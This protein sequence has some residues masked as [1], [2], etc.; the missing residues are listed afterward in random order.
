MAAF[1]V[2]NLPELLE[3]M[4][5]HLPTINVLIA[6]RVSTFWKATIDGSDQLQKALCFRAAKYAQGP[7]EGA[8][9]PVIIS[10]TTGAVD[11]L[12]SFRTAND[13]FLYNP[14]FEVLFKRNSGGSITSFW[15]NSKI[16]H[17]LRKDGSSSLN[18]MLAFQPPVNNADIVC[19]W[20]ESHHRG[21]MDFN[22]LA[23]EN[24]KGIRVEDVFAQLNKKAETMGVY[25]LDGFAC[26]V[27]RSCASNRLDD[28]D[29]E[30]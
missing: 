10:Q 28:S 29:D 19:K 2:L 13:K 18:K 3:N 1:N 7:Q 21:E 6:T 9:L 30:L 23:V 16:C 8:H 12:K 20:V 25:E 5:S 15:W 27:V 24:A 22:T 11:F 4:L 17:R 14:V 26:F